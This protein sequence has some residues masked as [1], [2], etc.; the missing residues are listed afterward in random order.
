MSE[1]ETGLL[2]HG[3]GIAFLNAC[4]S[5][6]RRVRGNDHENGRVNGRVNDL[7]FFDREICHETCHGVPSYACG[8]DYVNVIETSTPTENCSDPFCPPFFYAGF[9]RRLMAWMFGKFSR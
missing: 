8:L 9:L 1:S 4:A 2:Y 7:A 3:S 5:T 6:W